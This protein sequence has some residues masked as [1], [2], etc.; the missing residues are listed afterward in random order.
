MSG[1]IKDSFGCKNGICNNN[2]M[3]NILQL[4][5]MV[6]PTSDGEYFGFCKANIGCMMN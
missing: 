6:D 1:Y 2:N 5:S 3:T 4:H